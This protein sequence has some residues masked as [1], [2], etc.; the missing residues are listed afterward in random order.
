MEFGS[1]GTVGPVGRELIPAFGAQVP[2]ADSSSRLL[3]A[4]AIVVVAAWVGGQLMRRLGQ[5]A[6]LGE[7]LVGI[8]LGPS[9]LGLIW[10]SAVSF[11]F[12]PAVLVGLRAVAELGL[13][14][15]MFLV[16]VEVD[17]ALVRGSA[18]VATL[19]GQAS[20]IV[21]AILGVAVAPVVAAVLM[22]S[23]DPG[24]FAL[25]FG[26]AMAITAFPVLARL[27]QQMRLDRTRL[28]GLAITSAAVADV[29]AWCLL[30]I[31]IAIVESS[32]LSQAMV[33]VGAAALITLVAVGV[34]R[35]L[36]VRVAPLP[37]PGRSVWR[38]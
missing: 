20:I 18:R 29:I 25:F 16:G 4:V 33:T 13:V 38:C 17:L 23:A 30:A 15:F 1:I 27:L 11:L 26:V 31:A 5:P 2:S 3:L 32:G 34:V 36:L 28:G 8:L 22:P 35:P 24:T 9:V 12:P 7:I 10:P 37:L 21:P 19:V 6:V 14:L